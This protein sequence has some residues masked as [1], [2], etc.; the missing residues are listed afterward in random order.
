MSI[1]DS[2]GFIG[3]GMMGSSMAT[4]LLDAGVE[5]FVYDIDESRCTALVEQGATRCSSPRDLGERSSVAI[6]MVY[7][8]D[9]VGSAVLDSAD[10][11]LGGM[12][13]GDLYIDCTTNSLAMC[14]RITAACEQ[15][16]VQYLD[17]PVSGR[18][19]NLALMVGGDTRALDRARPVLDTFSRLVVHVGDNGAGTVAKLVNQYLYYSN[20]MTAVEG[21][22]LAQTAGRVDTTALREV[23][24]ASAGNSHALPVAFFAVDASQP[25][26]GKRAPLR[27][28]AKDVR[29]AQDFARWLGRVDGPIGHA[30]AAFDAAIARNLQTEEWPTVAQVLS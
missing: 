15:A 14:D 7:S 19:P 25:S 10:G 29:M 16:G 22:R 24:L 9:D 4:A 28:A 3:L 13:P 21:L 11:L 23:L 6:T 17:A 2:V 30:N 12:S 26:T 8:P 27:L 5:T 18:A 1:Q 20:F